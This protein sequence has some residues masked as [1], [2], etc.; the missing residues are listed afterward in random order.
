[1][2]SRT[3]IQLLVAGLAFCSALLVCA[4]V[5]GLLN[6]AGRVDRLRDRMG[7]D[8]GPSGRAEGRGLSGLLAPAMN[9]LSGLMNRLGRRFGPKG[10]DKLDQERLALIR[11]GL[12]GR[13]AAF[14]F[15]GLKA[16][17]TAGLGGAALFARWAFFPN[18]S[19]TWTLV[20]AIFLAAMGCYLPNAWRSR[21]TAKRKQTLLEELPDALDLLVVSVEAG[22]GLDQAL[23]RVSQETRLSG[24]RLSE[25]LTL[26]TLELR[27]GKNRQEALRALALRADLEDLNNLV[28]LIS[29]ADVFGISVARTLRIYSETLRTKRYQRAEEKA[30]KLPVKLLIPLILF[31]LPALF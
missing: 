6:N 27:A 21:R 20:C 24:P 13:G 14:L 12:R 5:M 25:E 15:Q 2:A 18:L 17:L 11:A 30:A 1:M 31:I 22:M 29:Q 28:T 4:G 9:A 23:Q 26:L 10:Q 3:I 8:P 7:K 16:L 19:L